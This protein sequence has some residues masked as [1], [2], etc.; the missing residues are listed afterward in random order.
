M[1]DRTNAVNRALVKASFT[2]TDDVS[3]EFLAYLEDGRASFGTN[4]TYGFGQ[5]IVG[6]LE[7]A[8]G[9]R[10][11]L[12]TNAL[13]Y[14]RKTRTIPAFAPPP[15]ATSTTRFFQNDVA[16]GASYTT[17]SK[18]TFNLEYH[19]HQA[20]FSGSDWRNWLDAGA[21]HIAPLDAELWYI[22]GYGAEQQEPLAKHSLF[23]RADRQDAFIPNLELTGFVNIDARDGSALAQAKADY[24]LSRQW[25]V[26]LQISAAFGGKH[27]DFGSLPGAASLFFDARRYF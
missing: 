7:W 4:L 9:D 16:V 25:T 2:L 21:L 11:N 8:G 18:I 27:S 19:Y 23:L 22:R 14:G 5:S 20:G 6:Y 24:D 12:V 1:P 17:E 13:G 15:L 26:G 10:A 3:P